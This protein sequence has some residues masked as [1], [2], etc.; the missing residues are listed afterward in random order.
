ME[1]YEAEQARQASTE[2][3][4]A[5]GEEVAGGEAEDPPAE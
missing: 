4:T 1:E 2:G 3:E 5:G